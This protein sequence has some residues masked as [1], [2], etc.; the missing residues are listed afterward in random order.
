MSDA[1]LRE[2]AGVVLNELKE[3]LHDPANR[4]L[5]YQHIVTDLQRRLA[6]AHTYALSGF[7]RRDRGRPIPFEPAR[8]PAAPRS[9]SDETK[10]RLLLDLEAELL[11]PDGG[12]AAG[13]ADGAAD[14]AADGPGEEAAA[15]VAVMESP[16]DE[17]PFEDDDPAPA[18]AEDDPLGL[19]SFEDEIWQ[20]L[21]SGVGRT[22][23][24][25]PRQ[26]V[27]EKE[28]SAPR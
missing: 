16:A 9:L 2:L 5:S 26:E 10:A 1:E 17:N 7:G 23:A 14:A 3:R 19:D 6:D 12:A 11:P 4:G 27:E 22:A 28:D 20:A 18:A 13:P 21:Q 15:F 24:P 25:L 8:V